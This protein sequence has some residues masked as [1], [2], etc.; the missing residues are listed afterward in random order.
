MSKKLIGEILELQQTVAT[1]LAELGYA[2]DSSAATISRHLADVAVLGRDF[3]E[4]TLPLFL[5]MD[6][7]HQ[8]ALARL[9]VSIKCDLEELQD[10]LSDVDAD[11]RSLMEFLNAPRT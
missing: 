6:R 11:L 4:N 10:A 8:E 2:D 1:R 3:A 7:D 9:I 5:T